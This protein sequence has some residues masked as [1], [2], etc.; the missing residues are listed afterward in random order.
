[1]SLFPAIIF[2]DIEYMFRSLT[3]SMF[4]D[5]CNIL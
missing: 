1:M 4:K 5:M 2:K 3:C